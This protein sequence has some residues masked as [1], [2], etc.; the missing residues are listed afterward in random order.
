MLDTSLKNVI[1]YLL[2]FCFITGLTTGVNKKWPSSCIIGV[3]DQTL[4]LDIFFHPLKVSLVRD[5]LI[6]FVIHW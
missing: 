6:Q 4:G 2:K 3:L 1:L 5:S